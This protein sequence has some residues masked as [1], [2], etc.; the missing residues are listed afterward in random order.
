M[1]EIKETN[2]FILPESIRYEFAF[3]YSTNVFMLVKKTQSIESSE[4]RNLKNCVNYIATLREQLTKTKSEPNVDKPIL[5]R[6]AETIQTEEIRKAQIVNKIVHCRKKYF[7][8][9]E[10]FNK[11][12]Q[13]HMKRANQWF[14]T[15]VFC[16][17]W[18]KS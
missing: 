2:Q 1:R 9:D 10:R 8:L 17:D 12:I 16:C 4:I 15:R 18:L 6:L 3:T 13:H 11:E 14:I 5:K 7:D